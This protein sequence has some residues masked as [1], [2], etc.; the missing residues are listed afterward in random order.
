MFIFHVDVNSAYLSWTASFLLEQGHPVDLRNIPSVVGGDPT[1]RRGIILAKSIPAKHYGIQTGDTLYE[2]KQKYPA[3]VVVSPDYDLY[4]RCSDSLYLLLCE[5]SSHVQRFSVD[6]CFL[7]WPSSSHTR[8]DAI[9]MGRDIKERIF[10][11]LGFTVNV[12]LSNN[13]LLAKMASELQKPN[14][15]HTLF[16]DEIKEKMWPLPVE[17][18][19]MV[20]RATQ[21]KLYK[22]NIRTIKDLAQT[23]PDFLQTIFKSHGLKIH[24][25]ANG[26]DDSVIE[27]K[28]TLL[29]KSIGNSTTIP[30]DITEK[31]D[32]HLILLALCER[33]GMRL[34]RSEGLAQVVSVHIKTSQFAYAMHQKKLFSA[35]DETQEIF[36]NAKT[37]LDEMDLKEPL[38]H[39]GIH[40]SELIHNDFYQISFLDPKDRAKQ[41]TLE[42]TI[43]KLRNRYGEKSIFRSCF[44]NSGMEPLQGGVHDEDYLMMSSIL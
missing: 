4:M 23:K 37:L 31:S 15:L 8:K 29:Q 27:P 26:I 25:Y 36:R 5:Y 39:L 1:K 2:A 9:R 17:D 40:V 13:K 44:V 24:L 35:T 21:K 41:R 43:D 28:Q 19:F 32:S 22:F 7:D 14:Q 20:G 16:P 33:V 10:H 34:R 11:E 18:L 12:G 38:R 42:R 6:E 3:L 30:Y